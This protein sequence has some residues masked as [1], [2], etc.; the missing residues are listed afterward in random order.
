MPRPVN[1]LQ[2]KEL[3]KLLR[4]N[5]T[6]VEKILWS[7][8]RGKQT[9][10]KW[11][12]QV[13]IGPYVADFYCYEKHLV[14]ELDGSQHLENKEYDNERSEYFKMLGIKTIRFWN[15]EVTKNIGGVMLAIENELKLT[16]HN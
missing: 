15:N 1:S 5:Q 16:L 7:K 10:Y 6:E 2:Q 8:L 9:G 14:I 11:K 4:S 3:R 13:S 12:R